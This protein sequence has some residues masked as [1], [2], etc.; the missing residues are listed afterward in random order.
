MRSFAILMIS[1]LPAIAHPG[2]IAEAEGHSHIGLGLGA[3][4]VIAVI[5]AVLTLRRARK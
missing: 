2:H 1:A 4:A 5:G 3:L